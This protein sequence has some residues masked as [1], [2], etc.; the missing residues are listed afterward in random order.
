[1]SGG[2]SSLSM[3]VFLWASPLVCMSAFSPS[4]PYLSKPPLWS[5]VPQAV[6]FLLSYLTLS[7]IGYKETSINNYSWPMAYEDHTKPN[8]ITRRKEIF[9]LAYQL[10]LKSCKQDKHE[11]L[12]WWRW[13]AGLS[14]ARCHH[15]VRDCEGD[16]SLFSLA[17]TYSFCLAPLFSKSSLLPILIKQ[18]NT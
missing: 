4:P 16:R 7:R 8:K 11:T 3:P 2:L 18:I 6:E 15:D 12:R 13:S 1:M 10:E 17:I 5:C 9:D 14:K